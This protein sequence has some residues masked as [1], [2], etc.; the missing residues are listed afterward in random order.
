MFACFIWI[1]QAKHFAFRWMAQHIPNSE[2]LLFTT[3]CTTV[4]NMQRKHKHKKARL[5]AF[6]FNDPCLDE[7]CDALVQGV[8]AL[9]VSAVLPE[10]GLD[11]K[12]TPT[13]KDVEVVDPD[14][15]VADPG[16][17]DGNNYSSA[18]SNLKSSSAADRTSLVAW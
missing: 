17:D 4:A 7:T 5:T 2:R 9:D 16:A 10:N 6:D 18:E 8:E 12:K 1:S 3:H 13:V 14:A 15:E 11:A